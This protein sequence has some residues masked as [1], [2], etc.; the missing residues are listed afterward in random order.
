MRQSLSRR[1]LLLKAS[2]I[3]IG[4]ALP[5]SCVLAAKP[6]SIK[7]ANAGGN[8]NLT[9]GELMRQQQFL[10]SFG[11]AP[12]VL[13]VADGSRILGGLVSRS[14][15]I[16]AMSGFGQ[17]FPAIER[18]A[19]IK[20]LAGGA[21]LPGLALFSA[22]PDV[23]VLKNLEGRTLG[24]GSIGALIYQ[25]TMALLQKYKVN[26]AGIRFVNVGSSADIFR[27]VA[28][29][30]VDAG[31][32]DV[33]LI[34]NAADHH[35]H[36]L[37]HGNM[38]VELQEYTYQGAWTV[39]ANILSERDALVRTLAAYA[40]LYRF[41]QN[42]ASRDAFFRARRTVFPSAAQSDHQAQ[43]NYI[44]TYKPFAVDLALSPERL[45]YMQALNVAFRVQKEILP[46]ERVADMSLA[47]DALR[48]LGSG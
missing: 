32:G 18:G 36:V 33:A 8:L 14:V 47:T 29:G 11:L 19:P 34:E 40:K 12:E 15:D 4:T 27:A 46:F 38:T 24:T 28:A 30:T 31:V 42:P 23:S 5:V 43:W 37:E 20:I 48:L 2:G 44:Q 10:E 3:A 26:T 7:I 41:V 35:V 25:L 16:S 13:G 9:M 6:V 1:E 22:R 45:R 21:L 17:A 39:A